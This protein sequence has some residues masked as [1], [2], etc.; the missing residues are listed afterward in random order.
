MT[1]AKGGG[2]RI[3]GYARVSTTEQRMDMQEDALAAIGASPVFRDQA[4]GAR[5]DRPGLAACLTSL[6]AGDTLAVWKLDRL[7]RSLPHLVQ[8]VAELRERGIHLRSLT[9]SIDTSTAHGRL[10]FG[11]FG[12]LAEFERELIRERIATGRKAAVARGQ[13]FGPKPKMTAS[14]VDL[15]RREL[16]GGRGIRDVARDLGVSRSTLYAALAAAD[17]AAA[18]AAAVPHEK[19]GRG[20]PRAAMG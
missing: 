4:S 18:R 20:R 17:E 19:R 2:G 3:V 7:G 9:E 16:A 11:L 13:R 10:L 8:V 12:T 6:N 15:A 1:E 5:D 14:K